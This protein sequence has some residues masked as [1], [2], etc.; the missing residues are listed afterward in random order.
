MF[1]SVMIFEDLKNIIESYEKEK[2]P[3]CFHNNKEEKEEFIDFIN[4]L[5]NEEKEQLVVNTDKI[6]GGY[7]ILSERKFD[8]SKLRL[9]SSFCDLFYRIAK[10][11][12]Q[13][14][15]KQLELQKSKDIL[16]QYDKMSEK[17]LLIEILKV[18]KS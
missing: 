14:Y 15:N 10:H 2:E 7:I 16:N 9:N 4:K 11:N 5:S 12:L 13:L 17:Q 18:L 1:S 3:N 6:L 8:S